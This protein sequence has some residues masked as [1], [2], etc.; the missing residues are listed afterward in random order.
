MGKPIPYLADNSEVVPDGF[1]YK[2]KAVRGSNAA[3]ECAQWS[4]DAK[5]LLCFPIVVDHETGE[6]DRQQIVEERTTNE[7]DCALINLSALVEYRM[8]LT[9]RLMAASYPFGIFHRELAACLAESDLFLWRDRRWFLF[10]VAPA[11][12][13]PLFP[14]LFGLAICLRFVVAFGCGTASTPRT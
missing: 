10:T 1:A 6:H 7:G 8:E 4:V 9:Q 3:G 13:W 2:A 11:A 12:A 5:Q 14:F